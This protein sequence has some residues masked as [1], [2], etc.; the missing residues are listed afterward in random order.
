MKM[1]RDFLGRMTPTQRIVL[2]VVPLLVLI[3][4]AVLIYRVVGT[5]RQSF[6]LFADADQAEAV[7]V[8]QSL[9]ADGVEYIVRQDGEEM[10][11]SIYVYVDDIAKVDMMRMRYHNMLPHGYDLFDKNS[12]GRTDRMLEIDIQRAMIGELERTLSVISGVQKAQVTIDREGGTSFLDYSESTAAINL[13][14]RPGATLG[15]DQI[16]GIADFV[17]SAVLHLPRENITII[18]QNGLNLLDK[19]DNSIGNETELVREQQNLAHRIE[20]NKEDK[21]EDHLQ[22]IYGR[23]VSASV[24]VELD[25]DKLSEAETKYATPLEGSEEGLV[26]DTNEERNFERG[27]NLKPEGAPG[28]EGNAPGYPNYNAQADGIEKR[29]DSIVQNYAINKLDRDFSVAQGGIRRMTASVTINM[30][31]KDWSMEQEDEIRQ[32][33]A[34]VIGA[35]FSRGDTISITA[36]NRGVFSESN[37]SAQVASS[38]RSQ[39][40]NRIIGWLIAVLMLGLMFSMVRGLVTNYLPQ[41]PGMLLATDPQSA[42]G[43]GGAGGGMGGG[44]RD[45]YVLRKLDELDSNKQSLMREEIGRM[46]EHNPDQVVALIRTWIMED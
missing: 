9:D 38:R 30:D 2:G 8:M 46:I 36:I 26:L 39:A 42:D 37:M 3:G 14:M 45:D 15:R 18:D 34:G 17:Q 20:R 32:L 21:L 22:G 29:N 10:Q 5:P 11:S 13:V 16:Q 27:I 28:V 43:G 25:F 19:Y 31:A 44:G 7:E 12:M 23:N 41:D 6:L 40:T 4:A 1:L 24:S 35:D 33:V